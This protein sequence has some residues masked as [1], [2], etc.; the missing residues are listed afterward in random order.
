MLARRHG[1]RARSMVADRI[2]SLPS[3]EDE[4]ERVL[5]EAI[6]RCLD[7]LHLSVSEH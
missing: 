3:G 7:Q 1:V 5:S 6:A 2:C 4:L